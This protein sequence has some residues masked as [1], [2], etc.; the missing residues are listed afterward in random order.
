M[1]V[2]VTLRRADGSEKVEWV[3]LDGPEDAAGLPEIVE[4]MQSALESDDDKAD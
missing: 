1:M 2:K 4:A 3:E